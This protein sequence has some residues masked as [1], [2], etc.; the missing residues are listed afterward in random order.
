MNGRNGFIG[1]L[2]AGTAWAADHPA[3]LH[4][5]QA[6]AV[7]V[8][9]SG[10]VE[11]V[12]VQPGQTV[13]QGELLLA[14][15][16]TVYQAAVLEARADI[17]RLTEDAAEARRDLDRVK[18][19]YARTVSSTTE[20]DAAKLRQARA[21]A[22]LAAAQ[23][24][25]E[26]ARRQLAET[27]L[28]APFDALVTDRQAEPGLVVAAQ[29]QPPALLTLA[30]AGE[31]LARARL[32]PAQAAGVRIGAAASVQAGGRS[33]SGRIV[34]LR[35]AAGERPAYWVEVA[36]PRAPGLMAGQAASIRLP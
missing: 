16:A 27:E 34:A 13:R 32:T 35:Y 5:S 30:H 28:R 1:L 11:R 2:M 26:R 10:V 33:L 9:V 6:V 29:C 8:P 4:W 14:L 20:L 7:S 31:I 19:L 3:E 36:V 22:Q 25:L 24:R 18:E 12:A 17:E 21:Q 23:A 15:D